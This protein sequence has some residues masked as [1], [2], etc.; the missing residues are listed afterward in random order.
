MP[1]PLN[2]PVVRETAKMVFIVR[3]VAGGSVIGGCLEN[4]YGEPLT[5]REANAL[6]EFENERSAR[7]REQKLPF[8]FDYYVDSFL[9]QNTI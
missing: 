7:R 1:T 3:C 8:A 5:K 4:Q 2:K 9:A 6:A